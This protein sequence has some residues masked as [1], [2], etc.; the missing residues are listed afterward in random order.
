MSFKSSFFF[1]LQILLL[2]TIT[3][4]ALA[5]PGS[6]TCQGVET[7]AIYRVDLAQGMNGDPTM[8]VTGLG[9]PKFIVLQPALTLAK[10]SDIKIWTFNRDL[11]QKGLS[12]GPSSFKWREG[13]S[14]A[15]IS[16]FVHDYESQMHERIQETL[17][18]RL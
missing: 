14:T 15:T 17:R 9:S 4:P 18:C 1:G 7:E 8:V 12:N 2:A 11:V 16:Y 13:S 3:S 5:A 10:N 6:L